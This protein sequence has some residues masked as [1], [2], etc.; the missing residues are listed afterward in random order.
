MLKF[1]ITRHNDIIIFIKMSIWHNIDVKCNRFV[2]G[3][4]IENSHIKIV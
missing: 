3:I 4:L 2:F 1:N